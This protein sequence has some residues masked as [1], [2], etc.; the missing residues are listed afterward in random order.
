MST[1]G[2][3]STLGPTQGAP[4]ACGILYTARILV[5]CCPLLWHDV[6]APQSCHTQSSLVLH[7]AVSSAFDSIRVSLHIFPPHEPIPDICRDRWLRPVQAFGRHSLQAWYE[8]SVFGVHDDWQAL[9]GHAVELNCVPEQVRGA[10]PLNKYLSRPGSVV[11]RCSVRCDFFVAGP[12]S[13][14]HPS[15]AVQGVHA[16]NNWSCPQPSAWQFCTSFA[17]SNTHGLP[18]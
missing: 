17:A 15:K 7:N 13:A 12:H 1:Q 8:Q 18:Q 11:K 14:V 16:Q 4:P 3:V 10:F 6:H 2:F 9:K 5:D